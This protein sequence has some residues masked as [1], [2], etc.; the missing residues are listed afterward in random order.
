MVT[1]QAPV[2][3]YIK[4]E[5]IACKTP[6]LWY[7]YMKAYIKEDYKALQFINLSQR[8]VPQQPG[9]VVMLARYDRYIKIQGKDMRELYIDKAYLIE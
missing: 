5:G 1:F 7:N 6:S 2:P 4:A 8:C 9:A 3:T